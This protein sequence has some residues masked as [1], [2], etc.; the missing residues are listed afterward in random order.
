ML[1]PNKVGECS[2]LLIDVTRATPEIDGGDA[3]WR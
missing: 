1:F 3:N 2:N